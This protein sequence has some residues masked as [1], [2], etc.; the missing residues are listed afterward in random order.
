MLL[1]A[2][3]FLSCMSH[4]E[5]TSMLKSAGENVYLNIPEINTLGYYSHYLLFKVI[6]LFK[7]CIACSLQ[8]LLSRKITLL[9][10][11]LNALQKK[12]LM[13]INF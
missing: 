12:T 7:W 2:M 8:H 13:G 9:M 6:M 5:P 11:P 1:R 4:S 3:H 10:F